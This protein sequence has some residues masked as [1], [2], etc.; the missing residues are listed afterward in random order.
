MSTLQE[1]KKVVC[2]HLMSIIPID[3][4]FS[5]Y[6]DDENHSI[7]FIFWEKLPEESDVLISTLAFS[8]Y[9]QYEFGKPYKKARLEL[10]GACHKQYNDIFQAIMSTCVFCVINNKWT[11]SPGMIFPDIV[12]M[13]G[14]SDTMQH[15][16]F[17]SPFLWPESLSC[18]YLDNVRTGWVMPIPIS[19]AEYQYAINHNVEAL[20][21]LLADNDIDYRDL[22]RAS[23]L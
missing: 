6:Y 14:V 11:L 16:Y 18:V 20:G 1:R 15:V 7:D 17:D 4:Q 13:Y 19:E 5:L 2:D 10:L 12:K 21:E 9:E 22:R 8:Y 3:P 23:V